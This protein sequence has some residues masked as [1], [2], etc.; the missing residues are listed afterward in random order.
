MNWWEDW[1]PLLDTSSLSNSKRKQ[2]KMSDDHLNNREYFAVVAYTVR[3]WQG[4]FGEFG[5]VMQTWDTV[6]GFHDFQEFSQP[7]KVFR[8]GYVSIEKGLYC[9]HKI[10]FKSKIM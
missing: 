6:K 10:F 2:Q 3:V 9:F 1:Y 5:T 7:P 4:G 8:W